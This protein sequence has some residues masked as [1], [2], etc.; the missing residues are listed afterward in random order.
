MADLA[1][2]LKTAGALRTGV[3]E[4]EAADVLRVVTSLDTFSQLYQ[5]RGLSAETAAERLI[6]IATRTICKA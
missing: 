6:A 3:S 5:G 4:S 1:R 2:R